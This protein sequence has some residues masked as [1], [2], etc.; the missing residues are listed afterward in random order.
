MSAKPDSKKVAF[1]WKVS[2][3]RFAMH[4]AESA[5]RFEKRPGGWLIA[6]R[7]LADGSVERHR[8]QAWEFRTRFQAAIDGRN[9]AG[10]VLVKTR[11]GAAAGSGDSDLTAQFPGKVR[12]IL[13]SEGERVVEGAPLMLLEAMKMEFSIKAPFEGVVKKLCV[14]EAQQLSPGQQLIEIDPVAAA[15]GA[16]E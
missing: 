13:V 14:A 9:L 2:G 7:T 16:S 1:N 15:G 3:T 5:W 11:A 12:K 10:D 8:F 6:E 4:E